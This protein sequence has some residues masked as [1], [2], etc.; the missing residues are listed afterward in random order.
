MNHRVHNNLQI[1]ASLLS[2]QAENS[3]QAEVKAELALTRS[4]VRALATL[5]RHLS[6]A[7]RQGRIRLRPFIAELCQQ[8]GEHAGV[9]RNGQ[10]R[11]AVEVEDMELDADHA[12]SLT[13]LVTEA[14]S[15]AVQH[16]F[17]KGRPGTITVTLR[18][19]GENAVLIVADD[20]IGMPQ[21]ADRADA[22]GLNLIRGFAS[23]LGGAA[24]ISGDDGTRVSVTFPLRR[25]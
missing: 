6:R 9:A 18:S 23:H 8:L 3:P 17:P 15:N 20:G 7:S 16:A 14:V 1:V 5:Y 11:M 22:L 12:D 24:A 25:D 19:D 13:L 10:V 4:R 2:M 21:G